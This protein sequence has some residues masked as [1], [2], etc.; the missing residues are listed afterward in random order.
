MS[1]EIFPPSSRG[2]YRFGVRDPETGKAAIMSQGGWS[3]PE[4]AAAKA[5]EIEALIV[6]AGSPVIQEELAD[7]NAQIR[8]L[9][10]QIL[11]Q[12]RVIRET[13]AERDKATRDHREAVER[14]ERYVKEA[15][16]AQ[17]KLK[18]SRQEAKE[19]EEK[20]RAMERMIR[21]RDQNLGD[22]ARQLRGARRD[23]NLV[24]TLAALLAGGLAFVLSGIQIPNINL[25]F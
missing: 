14:G 13:G 5:R 1:F 17:A 16:L 15:E 8:R 21:G 10:D 6:K 9:E 2:R 25:P 11:E 24:I 23:R 22:T 20:N 12:N 18:S 3:T 7:R 4:R 19:R